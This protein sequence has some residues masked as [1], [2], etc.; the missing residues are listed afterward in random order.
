MATNNLLNNNYNLLGSLPPLK[1][2]KLV[3]GYTRIVTSGDIN[4]VY[5]C[6]AGKKALIFR[7]S[8]SGTS[9]NSFTMYIGISSVNYR[10]NSYGFQNPIPNFFIDSGQTFSISVNTNGI[11]CWCNILEF[12]STVP[13]SINYLTSFINGNNTL[14]TCPANKVSLPLTFCSNA[15]FFKLPNYTYPGCGVTNNTA[16]T[17][18]LISYVVP[19]GG[20]PGAT[21]QYSQ[22]GGLSTLS[23]TDPFSSVNVIISAPILTAGESI[24]VN[25]NTASSDIL[26]YVYCYEVPA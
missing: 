14:Y 18:T 3:K 10:L 25:C 21:N 16:G 2:A 15:S 7:V 8:A 6:P 9:T 24:V 23:S 11:N 17:I 5:S 26:G 20:S 4:Q 22:S 1:G 19:N 12:D 13:I